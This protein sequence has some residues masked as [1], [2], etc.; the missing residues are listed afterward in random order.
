MRNAFINELMKLAENNDRIVLV[1]GDLGYSVL[2]CFAKQFESRF[3][4]VGVAEQ[5]MMGVASGLAHAGKIVFTY[6]IAN[7]ATLRCI[8]QI[9]NDVCYHH[10]NVKIV[11][12][13]AG[14]SYAT[15]GYTHFG[16]E[17]ISMMRSLPNMKVFSPADPIETTLIVK[18]AVVNEGPCYLRLGKAKEAYIHEQSKIFNESDFPL[19]VPVLVAQSKQTVL[20]TGA[21]TLHVKNYL[22]NHQLNYNLWSVPHIK[23]LDMETLKKIAMTSTVIYTCE[24]HQLSGGLGSA[25]L[26]AYER[27]HNKNEI[28]SLP[29]IKR[30]GVLDLIPAYIGSQGYMRDE[31]IDLSGLNN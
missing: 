9:R 26:E 2:E 27:L 15:Q 23:P 5:N 18:Q 4:N 16:L 28:T 3:I 22:I 19:I 1:T 6:S 13:G 10:A 31:C 30:L 14:F 29:T 21:I 11:S 17:D 12:V 25:I 24:E 7:F 8:E 20:A